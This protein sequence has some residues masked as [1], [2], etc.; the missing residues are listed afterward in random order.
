MPPRLSAA[1]LWAA[2]KG[3]SLGRWIFARAVCF[4]APYFS[5][6]SPRVVKLEKNLCE[7][8][9]WQKRSLQNHI[10]SI[11]AI[12]LCNLAEFC[13]GLM[14]D[15]SIPAEMRWIPKGMRVV[16]LKKA[17]GKIMARAVPVGEFYVSEDGYVAAVRVVL[18]NE[19]A[20]EVLHAEIQ[21][22]LSK[23]I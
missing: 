1:S 13:A 12:A 19:D 15:V 9:I 8:V 18:S 5:G 6:I 23:R 10:G 21:M 20:V 16:Y 14:T 3:N 4:K 7:G 17:R 2:L 11:H 22:W